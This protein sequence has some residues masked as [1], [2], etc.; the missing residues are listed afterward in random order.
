MHRPWAGSTRVGVKS[1]MQLRSEP[2]KPVCTS[3]VGEKLRFQVYRGQGKAGTEESR[4]VGKGSEVRSK[5]G[6]VKSRT[7]GPLKPR[8]CRESGTFMQRQLEDKMLQPLWKAVWQFLKMRN[9]E[10]PRDPAVPLVGIYLGGNENICAHGIL[11][12][13]VHSSII[14]NSQKVGTTQ[15]S[16]NG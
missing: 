8:Y 14:H 13:D 4:E 11:Y 5:A 6:D 10:L 7:A 2:G 3:E 12:T 15:M 9:I 1:F 16:T